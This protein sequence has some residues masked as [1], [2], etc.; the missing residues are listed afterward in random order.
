VTTT[1]FDRDTAVEPLGDGRFR[2]RI[3]SAWWVLRG[4]N[5][6][7]IAAIVTRAIRAALDDGGE[8]A[9]RSLTVHFLAAPHEG[10]VELAVRI[11]RAGRSMTAV[12]VRCEQDGRPVALA[13]AALATEYPGATAYAGAM[14][15]VADPDDIAAPALD[16]VPPFA[17]NFDL[18]PA[19]GP[20]PF[21]SGTE[22][23]TGGWLRLGEPRPLD[24][25]L[26]V[27]MCDGWW[28]APF[29]V[30]DRPLAAPTIDL[31]V[32]VRAPLPR[33]HD[34]VLLDARSE[35]ARDGFFEEDVRIFA[36]D[37][38]LLAQSRQLALLL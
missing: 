6:G 3:D 7:Y 2:A 5:G 12:T 29:G 10:D 26:V 19:L 36:R 34:F 8:R 30:V 38:T 21:S 16:F 4:P 23:R 24:E 28:P 31:T 14:P 33:E 35:T 1:R 25:A 15:E 37:G 13:I 32:H 27:A 18:R 20:P 11:E 17:R 9:L 22:P